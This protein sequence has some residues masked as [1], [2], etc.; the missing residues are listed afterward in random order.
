MAWY[1]NWSEFWWMCLIPLCSD[2][3]IPN[4]WANLWQV[5]LGSCPR[6]VLTG[7]LPSIV[8]LKLNSQLRLLFIPII[9]GWP[10]PTALVPTNG[11]S[12]TWVLEPSNGNPSVVGNFRS[13]KPSPLDLK[14]LTWKA[15]GCLFFKKKQLIFCVGIYKVKTALKYTHKNLILCLIPTI[16]LCPL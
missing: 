8:A 14:W 7:D 12:R 15:L 13:Q 11:T 4:P 2:S 1:T 5:A 3:C 6:A 9:L 10:P 16:F